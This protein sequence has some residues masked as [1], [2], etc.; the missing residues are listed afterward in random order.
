MSLT[1]YEYYVVCKLYSFV[2]VAYY[3]V[4]CGVWRCNLIH[5]LIKKKEHK[6]EWLKNKIFKQVIGI[7]KIYFLI[8]LVQWAI[9]QMTVLLE[10]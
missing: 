9:I 4:N 3:I 7:A 6:L 2:V 5:E 10:C 1:L 8:I